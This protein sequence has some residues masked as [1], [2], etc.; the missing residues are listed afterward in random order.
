MLSF[1]DL[2]RQFAAAVHKSLHCSQA[3]HTRGDYL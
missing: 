3:N 1:Y 2:A